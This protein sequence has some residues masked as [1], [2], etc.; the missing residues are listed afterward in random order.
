MNYK[1][2]FSTDVQ[3]QQMASGDFIPAYSVSLSNA[4][5]ISM[6]SVELSNAGEDYV[7]CTVDLAYDNWE[8]QGLIDG[9]LGAAK[10]TIGNIF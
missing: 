3:I 1:S 4:Y 5:P 8:E 7:R 6:D 2:N 10:T 9:M